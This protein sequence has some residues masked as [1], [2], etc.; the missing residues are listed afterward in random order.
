MTKPPQ[1]AQPDHPNVAHR[2][3]RAAAAHRFFG[4]RLWGWVV[5]DRFVDGL[6]LVRGDFRLV[7]VVCD[8]TIEAW[9][10]E[11]KQVDDRLWV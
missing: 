9:Y 8:G 5:P 7:P 4:G 11:L 10:L 3:P 1:P 2:Q 6:G